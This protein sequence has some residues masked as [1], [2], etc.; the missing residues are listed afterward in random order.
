MRKPQAAPALTVQA[1]EVA[2]ASSAQA[3]L[4]GRAVRGQ[5]RKIP[6]WPGSTRVHACALVPR[7]AGRPGGEA[8]PSRARGRGASRLVLC[9]SEAGEEKVRI[10]ESSWPTCGPRLSASDR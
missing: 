3:K 9:E 8:V 2:Q 1:T 5:M 7:R 4:Q 10:G 6:P